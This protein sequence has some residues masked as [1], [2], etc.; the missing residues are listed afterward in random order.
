[1]RELSLFSG[2]GGGL[3]ATKHLLGWTT[4]GYVE[5]EEYCQRILAQRIEDGYLDRAPIF[6]DI[7]EFIKSG[8]ARE[9]RG[10]ADVVTGGFPCQPFS[11]AGKRVGARDDRN[12]FP[13]TAEVIEK[14]QPA[15]VFLENVLGVK[16]LLPAIHTRLR[17]MGYVI[18][19]RAV[20][21]AASVGGPHIRKR[22]W[23]FAYHHSL[24]LR[25]QS[26]RW[27]R[28]GREATEKLS[29]NSWWDNEPGVDRIVH[30]VAHGVDRLTA[31]GNGQVPAVAASAWGL[32]S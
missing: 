9:Y 7:R 21:G 32:F 4:V 29:R 19:R 25:D 17:S 11:Q 30:G 2:A 6:G 20:V 3:L 28:Q 26:G 27:F 24:Q 23:I 18:P 10:F 31:I 12:L 22:V 13:E 14:V 8:E 1:M 16:G 5:N 15:F